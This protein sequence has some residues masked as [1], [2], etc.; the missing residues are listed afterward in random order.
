VR[1]G[2]S[3]TSSEPCSAPRRLE[4]ETLML[5]V[6][7]RDCFFTDGYGALEV[8][9]LDRQALENKAKRRDKYDWSPAAKKHAL[10]VVRDQFPPAAGEA[11]TARLARLDAAAKHLREDDAEFA[12]LL[13]AHWEAALAAHD[14]PAEPL[15]AFYPRPGYLERGTLKGWVEAE[16]NKGQPPNLG[17]RRPKPRKAR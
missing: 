10:D 3:I 9:R 14:A 6:M 17:F 15:A 16:E 5:T 2:R 1:P 7:M 4:F 13:R 11:A 8:R 12:R